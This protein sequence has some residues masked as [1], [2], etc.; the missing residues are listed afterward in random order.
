MKSNQ[1]IVILDGYTLNP[2]DQS[3]KDLESLGECT[4]FDRTH[5]GEVLQRARGAEILLTNK[6]VLDRRIIE[7]LPN[8]K[9]IGVMATGYNV[10]D[11]EAARKRRIPVS[12]VPEYATK[13]VAQMVFALLLEMTQHVAH[14]SET[15]FNGRWTASQDFC[16][17]DTPLIELDRLTMG[18]IGYGRIGQTVAQ[19]ARTFGM[20]VLV[21]D[22]N[23]DIIADADITFINL[24]DLFRLSDVVSLHCPL[25]SETHEIV[26]IKRLA[27]MKNTALLINTDRGPLVNEYDLAEALNSGMIAGACLDVLSTE[28]PD[29]D[30]PLLR[31]KNCCITPHIAW[32]THAA[33]SRLMSAVVNNVKAF[34]RGE[35]KNV[36]NSL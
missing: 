34:L 33:R 19:I 16:Y 9:Y 1:K 3:W 28:P 21:N 15:V 17:W 36:V 32:A 31:A 12:N 22:S 7:S 24:E 27:L 4:I 35:L 6:T 10:V 25:T 26:D 14:H 29:A 30:N 18:I 2:G 20:K 5:Y 8:L 11:I 13:S 23:P